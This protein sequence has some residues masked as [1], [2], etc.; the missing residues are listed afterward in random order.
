MN[1]AMMKTKL[2][3]DG[4]VKNREKNKCLALIWGT[5][6]LAAFLFMRINKKRD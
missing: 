4:Q 2:N 5:L 6:L 1:D 3:S